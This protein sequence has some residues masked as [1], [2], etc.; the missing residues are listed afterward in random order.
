MKKY[1]HA[2]TIVL[3]FLLP[4]FSSCGPK[5][6]KIKSDVEASLKNSGM[7][8]I[9]A[10]V[11]KGV[12][13]LS[14]E[15]KDEAGRSAAESTVA[16]VKGVKQVVNNCTV[17]APPPAP[18]VISPDDALSKSVTDATKDY[19]GVTSSV[20]D[21]VI[22]LTG[23]IKRTDLQKLMMTLQSLKPKKVDNKLTIK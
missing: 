3:I 21:G 17:A 14:G 23:D 11:D 13:T 4:F 6:S 9:S 22:T 18:V 19:P 12:V 8:E 7:P 10:T 16:K 5:D 15:C 20:K 2:L 1:S